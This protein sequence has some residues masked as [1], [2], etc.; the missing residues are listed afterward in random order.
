M[1]KNREINDKKKLTKAKFFQHNNSNIE[2]LNKLNKSD[3]KYAKH[4][5]HKNDIVESFLKY[6]GFGT[7][8][9]SQP[10]CN[11]CEKPGLW[12]MDENK[13][14]ACHCTSCGHITK[15]PMT[16]SQYM[17]DQMEKQIPPELFELIA[18]AALMQSDADKREDEKDAKE[19]HI[20][21]SD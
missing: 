18:N 20:T 7:D 17:M 6:M 5:L 15:K 8:V 16:V 9:L 13:K 14:G 10:V 2:L 21:E 12:G 4:M 1:Y 3:I 11:K 19:I